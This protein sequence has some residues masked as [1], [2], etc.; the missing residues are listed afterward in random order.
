MSV[1]APKSLVRDTLY[2]S[3]TA[4]L[5]DQP[6]SMA[7]ALATAT[8]SVAF[9]GGV[10]QLAPDGFDAA[11]ELNAMTRKHTCSSRVPYWKAEVP[12]ESVVNASVHGPPA[13]LAR[14]MRNPSSLLELSVHVI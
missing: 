4:L 8:R 6:R 3:S 11:L 10:V 7:E 9:A 2:P 13:L 5:S 12:P 1:Q 14:S